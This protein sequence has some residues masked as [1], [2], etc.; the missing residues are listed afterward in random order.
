MQQWQNPETAIHLQAYETIQGIRTLAKKAVCY[1]KHRE[2]IT[3][4]HSATTQQ[5]WFLN[6]G[7]VFK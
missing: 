5:T 4:P 7:Q 2:A 1:P 3:Q 6:T